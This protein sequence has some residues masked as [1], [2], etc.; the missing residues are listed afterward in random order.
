M[1]ILFATFCYAISVNT[2]KR[3]LLE[4]NALEITAFGLLTVG[5]PSFIYFLSSSI[6][7]RIVEN[8]AL[9]S[10]VFYTAVLAIVSTSFALV[11]FNNLIRFSTALFAS[12]VTYLIPLVAIL[13]GIVDGEKLTIIQLGGT[14]LLLSGV[15]LIYKKSNT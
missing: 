13:W 2:I 8:P 7:E 10:G 11:L 1:I 15:I 14:I 6:P 3:F 12:S 9:Y 5:L 4:L